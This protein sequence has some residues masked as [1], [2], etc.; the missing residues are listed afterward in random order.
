MSGEKLPREPRIDQ[1]ISGPGAR[2]D[3]WRELLDVAAAWSS[4]TASRA[5]FEA[6]LAELSVL[7]EYYAYPSLRLLDALRE[8]AAE[9]DARTTLR[10]VR[11]IVTALTTHSFHRE[12]DEGREGQ[13]KGES[14]PDLMPPALGRGAATARISRL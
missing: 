5:K 11:N 1:F 7:E 10:M 12:R 14:V 13:E 8:S 9:D 3:R 2:L 4:G 6:V